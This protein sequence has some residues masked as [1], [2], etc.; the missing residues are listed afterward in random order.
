MGPTFG[1][2][3]MKGYLSQK[4][5]VNISQRRVALPLQVVAP[6]YHQRRQANTARM[7]NPIPYRADYFEHKLHIDQNEKLVMYGV[8]H[9][10]AI[11][12]HSRFIPAGSTMPIKNNKTI[13]ERI[14][15]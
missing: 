11:D 4:H 8:T 12:G 10:V 13:Y 2:K 15:R 6:V 7:I 9:V 14:F 5:K 3:V 1:R